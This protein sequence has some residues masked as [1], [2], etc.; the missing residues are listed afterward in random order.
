MR[1]KKL[2]LLGG[3]TAAQFLRDYWQ[4][5]PLLVRH[6]VPGFTGLLPIKD[7]LQLT[8]DE[9]VQSRLVQN[10][11]EKWD[12]QHGPFGKNSFKTLA[13]KNWTLLVQELNHRVPAA[14]DL[15]QQFSFI[16]HARL[17]DLM[18][19]YAVPGGGVGAHVDSY[20]VF[21]LQGEGTRRWEIS[22]QKDLTLVPAA[23]LKLL[24]KFTPQTE[25]TLGPGDMLYLPPRY[26]H[27]GTAVTACTTYSIGFRAPSHQELATQFLIYL[28]DHISL[29]GMYADPKLKLQQHPAEISADMI[30][31]TKKILAKIKLN[32][33][34]IESFLGT[35]LS[36][37]KPHI[38]FKPPE[39]TINE[40]TFFAKANQ[41]GVRLAPETQLLF[42][43][44]S[45]F[46]NGEAFSPEK[47]AQTFFTQLAD[48]RYAKLERDTKV[49][50]IAQ[51]CDWYNNGYI[52]FAT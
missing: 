24:K 47:S 14:T 52:Q 12:L 35:Y 7:L 16:P 20:D 26:A 30:Q 34:L 5:K 2:P 23:P 48:Q 8:Q 19:S 39:K 10:Q 50:L 15:L 28:Q 32:Q 46:I 37:P 3:L 38:F 49:Q 9:D 44:G 18:V 13:Q 25:W 33:T 17:D 40:K 4:K 29:D 6:A 21:L 11:G 31:Q 36:E 22:D 45:F 42:V 43:K 41:H 51:L 27:K 1:V